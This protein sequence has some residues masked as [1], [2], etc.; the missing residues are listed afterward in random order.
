MAPFEGRSLSEREETLRRLSLHDDRLLDDILVAVE[1]ACGGLEP[2]AT[3]LVRLG[4]LVGVGGSPSSFAAAAAT[5]LASGASIDDLVDALVA[6]APVVG[7]ARVVDA[8]PKLALGVGYDVER[9]FENPG[10]R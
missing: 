10:N 9:D 7:T 5:G 3:A 4:A 2:R 6:A 8:A 1:G